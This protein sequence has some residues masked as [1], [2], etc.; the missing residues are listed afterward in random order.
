MF[1]KKVFIMSI[2]IAKNFCKVYAEN[3][4]ESVLLIFFSV[5]EQEK[6]NRKNKKTQRNVW[7]YITNSC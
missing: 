5:K 1:T 3:Y 7:I 6:E 4:M 2:N